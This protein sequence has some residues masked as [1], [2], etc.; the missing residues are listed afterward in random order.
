MHNLGCAYAGMFLFHEAVLMF[1]KAY[2]N[3]RARETEEA[4]ALAKRL[5]DGNE[6]LMTP[7]EGRAS[8]VLAKAREAKKLQDEEGFF[9][10]LTEFTDQ[11]KDEY[12]QLS[13][14]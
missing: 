2:E 8:E 4:Y 5:E 9:D 3:N 7:A 6:A 14:G 13:L 11:L 12:R 1:E 10:R